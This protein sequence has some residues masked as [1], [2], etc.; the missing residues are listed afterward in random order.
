MITFACC[1]WRKKPKR[2]P[3][4]TFE[5]KCCFMNMC[6]IMYGR[7][8]KWHLFC[9]QKTHL[10]LISIFVE[11][12]KIYSSKHYMVF[13]MFFGFP[14]FLWFK[15][16]DCASS[17]DQQKV[18]FCPT[19]LFLMLGWGWEYGQGRLMIT[20][21]IKCLNRYCYSL[22]IIAGNCHFKSLGGEKKGDFFTPPRRSR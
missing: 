13:S 14:V 8:M 3:K 19:S 20:Y 9:W 4:A 21:H 6:A 17:V 16:V 12:W 10:M 11:N 15:Q 2:Y 18:H 22:H 5:T 1:P 7:G